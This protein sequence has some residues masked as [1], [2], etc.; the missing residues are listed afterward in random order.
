MNK[1]STLS[2]AERNY[3]TH[4]KKEKGITLIAL[5]VTIVV[6]TI[7]TTVSVNTVLGQNGIIS[8]AKQAKEIYS[9]TIVQEDEEMK[10]LLNEMV[11]IKEKNSWKEIQS[12]TLLK[13]YIYNGKEQKWVPT[14]T[15]ENGTKLIKDKDYTVEYSRTN[16]IDAGD[17][18]VRV[19][20]CGN[21]T[22]TII[23]KYTI[24]KANLTITTPSVT[25][26]FNGLPMSLEGLEATVEG[27]VNGE[28]ISITLTGGPTEVGQSQ[29]GY[30]INENESTAKL[31]NY[32]I[33][34]KLGTLTVERRHFTP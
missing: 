3:L 28:T 13:N 10:V 26:E 6:L 1:K 15:D 17:I 25:K 11:K 5:V 19:K 21:Y 22:G 27:L 16:F 33:I 14:V 8:K 30:I 12:D 23:K 2:K 20:G 7:L 24:E 29:C 31:K 32:N 34:E 9:N 18:I 4:T